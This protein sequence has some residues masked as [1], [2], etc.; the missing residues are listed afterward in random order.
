MEKKLDKLGWYLTD[1]NDFEN[2]EFA[3]FWVLQSI[4]INSDEKII[5]I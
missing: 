4:Q 3:A 1:K 2:I 5:G